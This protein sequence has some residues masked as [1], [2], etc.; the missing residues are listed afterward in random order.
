[1]SV[2]RLLIVDDDETLREVLARV[3]WRRPCESDKA[4]FPRDD[5]QRRFRGPSLALMAPHEYTL[6]P[7]DRRGIRSGPSEARWTYRRPFS[8]QST[9]AAHRGLGSWSARVWGG[10]HGRFSAGRLPCGRSLVSADRAR[11]EGRWVP[12]R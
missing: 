10:L 7:C 6:G 11:L 8:S 2:R 5:V 9:A 1:M 12:F 3:H 4:D